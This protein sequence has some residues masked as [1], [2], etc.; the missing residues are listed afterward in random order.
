MKNDLQKMEIIQEK[1]KLL[2]A[3]QDEIEQVLVVKLVQV[4]KIREAF[5]LDFDSM[6]GGILEAID[7]IRS[8]PVKTEEWQMIGRKF[9]KSNVKIKNQ[10]IT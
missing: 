1:M 7:T 9:C 8:D 3:E 4:L 10:R 2:K 5:Q 6:I